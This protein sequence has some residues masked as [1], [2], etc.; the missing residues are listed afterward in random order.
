MAVDG[1]AV[2]NTRL[3]LGALRGASFVAGV[4]PRRPWGIR[5]SEVAGLAWFLSS[6]GARAAVR[7]NL[8]HIL[9]CNPSVAD[10]VK[11]FQ[12]GVL[13]YWDT[14]A[15]PHY[16]PERVLAEVDIHGGAHL[17]Q[18]LERGRGAVVCTAHLSSVSFVG[19]IMP[20]LGFKLTGVLEAM[21]PREL[22]E[23]FAALRSAS[24]ARMIPL[25]PAAVRELILALR[26]NELLGL[27]TDRDV[28]GS[29]VT[30]DFFD[31]P[32]TFP[33]GPASLALRSGAPVLFA[34]CTRKPDGRFDAWIEPLG[35]VPLTGDR[36]ADV[37]AMTQAIARG[38]QYY[39]ASHPE[40]WTVF[41]KRWPVRPR[42]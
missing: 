28:T 14:F 38:L 18:A 20:A 27:V 37:P 15:I 25:S 41:Q 13:N 6:P 21:A 19:Q 24:G 16:T 40:Q 36:Q 9:A 30:V 12:S 5:I 2:L 11:V 29:G 31:A 42:P 32:T 26:R 8:R 17:S 10:V 23:Y 35:E 1:P 4:V 7:E 3:L 34:V 33:E 39:I 22:A